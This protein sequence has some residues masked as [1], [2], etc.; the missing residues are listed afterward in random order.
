M[1]AV[2]LMFSEH[3]PLLGQR[4]LP[5]PSAQ[6]AVTKEP[7]GLLTA[8]NLEVK[9]LVLRFSPIH[10]SATGVSSTHRAVR[11]NWTATPL[12]TRLL[13]DT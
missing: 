7:I 4:Q 8:G 6:D 11:G 5:L 10:F 1:L 2:W 3:L 13:P 12:Q 9:V